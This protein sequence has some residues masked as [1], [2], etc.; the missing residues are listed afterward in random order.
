MKF[1]LIIFTI[2]LNLSLFAQP[3]FKATKVS[4]FAENNILQSGFKNYEIVTLNTLAIHEFVKDKEENSTFNLELADDVAVTLHLSNSRIFDRDKYVAKALTAKGEVILP[5]LTCVPMTGYV[6]GNINKKASLTIDSDFISG[7]IEVGDETYYIEPLYD[8]IEHANK[9]HYIVYKA[10]DVINTHEFKCL[11]TDVADHIQNQNAPETPSACFDVQ[12]AIASDNSMFVKY[13]TTTGV[14]NHNIT[15][16]NNVNT[17]YV[18]AFLHQLNFVIVTQFIVT[19]S[20]GDPWSSSTDPN[21]LLNSFTSWGTANGFGSTVIFDLGELWSNRDFDGSTIG[22]AWVDVV[23]TNFKYHILQDWTTNAA[24]LRCMTSH[25]IG[26]NFSLGHD[27]GNADIMAP[28]VSSSNTWSATSVSEMNTNLPSLIPNCISPCSGGGSAPATEFMSRF[29]GICT[30]ST[31]AFIDQTANTPT[32]WSWTF[33][34]GTPATSTVQNPKVTYNSTGTFTVTL[35]ATNAFG[36]ITKT[37]TGYIVV[38]STTGSKILIDEPFEGATTGWTTGNP[39]GATTW[40][41]ANNVQGNTPGS[42]ALSILNFNYSSIGQRDYF[43]SPAINLSGISN[44]IL[45]LKHAYRQASNSNKDS[46]IISVSTDGGATFPNRIFADGSTT[47]ATS[48]TVTGSFIPTVVTDWCG[49]GFADCISYNLSAFVGNTNVKIRF[50]NYNDFGNNQYLDNIAVTANCFSAPTTVPNFSATPLVTCPGIPIQFTDL[51]TN[52]PTQWLWTFTGGNPATSTLQNPVVTYNSVGLY[53]VT[54]KATNAGGNAT[55]TKTNYIQILNNPVSGFTYTV[56]GNTVTFT[57]T[58]T[59]ATSFFWDFGDGSTS[60]TTNPTYTFSAGGTFIV[61]LTASNSCNSNVFNNS[62]TILVPPIASFTTSN[63]RSGCAPLTVNF[64]STSTGATTYSWSFQGGTPS[65]STVANP[66]VNYLTAGNYNVSLTVTNAAGSNTTSQTNYI[67]VNVLPTASFTFV[68]NAN[69]VNFTN[70]STNANSYVWAFGDGSNS[71]QTNPSHIYLND[72]IYNVTLTASNGCGNKTFILPITISTLPTASFNSSAQTACGVPATNTYTSTA[73]SNTTGVKWNFFGGNPTTSTSPVVNVIY[74]T[75]GSYDVQF[76]AFNSSGSDT[77][78]FTNYFT[79]SPTATSSYTFISNFLTVNFTN[80]SSNATSYLWE[81]GDATTSTTSN[82]SKTY[83]NPGTY[84]VKLTATGPCGAVV[85]TQTITVNS[86]PVAAFSANT[87]VGCPGA[88]ISF[89]SQSTGANSYS[90]TFAGGTPSTST[91]ANPTVTYSNAGIYGVTLVVTNS[92]GTNTLT[93]PNYIQINPIATSSYTFT[94]NFLT[95]NFTNTSSNATTYLWEFGDATTS[96]TPNPSK[97]YANPGTYTVK[98]T[99]T[100][101]CG[102]V[103]STQTFT[104]NSLPVAAF[105]ANTTTSCTG[106]NISFSSQSTGATSY[107]W[108]FPGGTPS[109]STASNPTV[110]YNNTGTYNVTLVVTNSAGT[111]TLTK[112]NYIQINPTAT[113]SYTFASNFL[114]VNFTNTSTNATTYLWEFGDATT[115]TSA[116]PSKTYSNPGT[117][118]V[119][120]T[121]TG[122]C[123]AVVSTQTITVNSLPVAAFSANTTFGCPG[124]TISFTSQSTGA[125]TYSWTFVGG[126]PSTSTVANPTVTYSNAGTYEVMLVVTNS[127]GNNTLT[128]SNYIQINPTTTANFT[129]VTN[130]L[131]VNYTNTSSNATNYLWEFGDATTSTLSNPSKTYAIPGT[132]TVKLTANGPCGSV[133]SIQTITVNSLPVAAFSANTTNGCIGLNT[134]FTSQSTGASSYSW[135]FTGGTP[136]TS[137]LANPL[138]VYNTPGIFDVTLVVTNTAGNSTLTKNSYVNISALPNIGFNNLPNQCVDGTTIALS[139]T[140]SGGN[141]T[142]PGINV[143]NFNPSVAGIGTHTLTYTV[144][145]GNCLTSKSITVTVINCAC[146]NPISVNAG[147]DQTLCLN[148]SQSNKIVNLNGTLLGTTTLQWTSSGTGTFSNATSLNGTYTPSALDISNGTVTL[149][150]KGNDPDGA[151]PCSA[152]SDVMIIKL[153][154]NA[155]PQ[156]IGNT[157]ICSGAATILSTSNATS[158]NWSPAAVFNT[159]NLSSVTANPTITT[160]CVLTTINNLGCTNT[161]NFT[162]SVSQAPNA[163]FIKQ[164]TLG[165][166]NVK[167]V[168]Q[169]TGSNNTFSWNFGDGITSTATNP[170]HIYNN[171]GIYTVTLICSNN[172]GIDTS[173]VSLT[174]STRTVS[175]FSIS[176]DTVCI[177]EIFQLLNNSST[178]STIFN[179][180]FPNGTPLT[181]KLKN[182]TLSYAIAGTYTITLI[183][184]NGN[185]NNSFTRKVVVIDRPKADFSFTVATPF[186]VSFNTQINGIF[187]DWNFGDGTKSN[188]KNPIHTYA[189]KGNYQITLVVGNQCGRDTISRNISVYNTATYDLNLKINLFPNPNDGSFYLQINSI[190]KNEYN[191]SI[192]NIMGQEVYFEKVKLDG[193]I[194]NKNFNLQNLNSGTYFIKISNN[195]VLQTYKMIIQK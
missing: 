177:G 136:A 93:K 131:N 71:T 57:N 59:N 23:C 45:S 91:A 70:G 87:N 25:E 38:G 92:A 77:I 61:T 46:L 171:D 81:F 156:V 42:K 140:P 124:A 190:E 99:A 108:T 174:I 123:G 139:A 21:V 5:M 167:F 1:H 88:S 165:S 3:I 125:N 186:T 72:G 134:N 9:N 54:L 66:I 157:Q 147:L 97:T 144:G 49:N 78:Y 189:A 4:D 158:Y 103:V 180:D 145:T 40:A 13:V 164:D 192:L 98:L 187:Y 47:Y 55:L 127:A 172:C 20:G 105:S 170:S 133:V 65:T 116:N 135:S 102:A 111:N 39:D 2:L 58:S 48:S 22:L 183:A 63:A 137:T 34:G 36:S 12:L 176:K 43:I 37:K 188:L 148:Q 90:W 194:L 74:N 95:V 32:S 24:F 7:Y 14:Q 178:N 30:G 85:S 132:Y 175:L 29:T 162:I 68:R 128:K 179:W 96:T 166:N 168:N 64:Q 52:S 182:P 104:I 27:V 17:N 149:T 31:I 69:N 51:S 60:T 73:S 173:I 41:V 150:L 161:N 191:L 76:I 6:E 115:S 28:I 33:A 114:N 86:L 129:F 84:T 113:S 122:L 169:S 15:V 181:S 184:S 195:E 146:T 53:S 94:S 155:P 18:S 100:G 107:S 50:E 185:F 143:N 35:V 152:S 101:L 10:K 62:I 163:S 79:I 151:G 130:F 121:A 80:T 106:A 67:S 119:K 56:S 142:G 193:D 138:V 11:M 153:S 16:I 82:P 75:I 141:Y 110:T 83:A 159:T 44:V 117:Y 120:L 8:I 89:T 118:T 126:T 154:A 112:P 19:V 160:N 26:H 109:T